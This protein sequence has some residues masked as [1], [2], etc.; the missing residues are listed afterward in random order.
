MALKKLHAQIISFLKL[1]ALNQFGR[2]K[3]FIEAIGVHVNASILML[4][5]NSRPAIR[6]LQSLRRRKMQIALL[7]HRMKLFQRHVRVNVAQ[8]QMRPITF[9]A[10]PKRLR[11]LPFA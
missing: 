1:N 7:L 2:A 8:Q 11:L 6:K 4:S 10:R 5:E 9:P 3:M